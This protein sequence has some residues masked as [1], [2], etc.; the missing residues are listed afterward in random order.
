MLKLL[1]M[2]INYNTI[3]REYTASFLTA[4]VVGQDSTPRLASHVTGFSVYS[5]VGGTLTTI[6]IIIFNTLFLLLVLPPL[7]CAVAPSLS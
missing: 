5:Y 7:S 4:S 2:C 3:Y 6:I 1:V